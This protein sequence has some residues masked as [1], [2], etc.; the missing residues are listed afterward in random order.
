MF[1]KHASSVPWTTKLY[2]II[3]L[4]DTRSS[5][6][7]TAGEFLDVANILFI[8]FISVGCLAVPYIW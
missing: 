7:I 1:Q 5:F 8:Y 2:I 4:L 3:N 6:F